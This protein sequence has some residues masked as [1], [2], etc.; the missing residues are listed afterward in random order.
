MSEEYVIPDGLYY[1]E[2]HE[3]AKVQEDGVVLREELRGNYG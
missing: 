2:E 3:W 1:S